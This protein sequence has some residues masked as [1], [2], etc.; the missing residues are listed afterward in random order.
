MSLIFKI[1]QFKFF[2]LFCHFLC[3]K[4]EWGKAVLSGG[5]SSVRLEV[6][7]FFYR[8]DLVFSMPGH[9]EIIDSPDTEFFRLPA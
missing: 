6:Y 7:H 2:C 1:M 4:E 8:T 5:E 9:S 3:R